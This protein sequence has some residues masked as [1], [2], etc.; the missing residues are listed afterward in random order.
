MAKLFQV[1][2]HCSIILALCMAAFEV[3]DWFNPYM[4]FLGLPIS[5]GLLAVFCLLAV[6]QAIRLLYCENKLD[7]LRRELG[8]NRKAIPQGKGRKARGKARKQPAGD[9]SPAA[10]G[11]QGAP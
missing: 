7:T 9:R 3:L 1:T 10:A 5:T 4:N 11:R 8:K 6:L 2:A